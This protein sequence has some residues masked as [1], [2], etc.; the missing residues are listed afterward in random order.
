M[1][2]LTLTAVTLIMLA[3]APMWSGCTSLLSDGLARVTPYRVEIV[4]GNVVTREQVAAVKPGMTRDQ[5]RNALGAPL[6][7]DAFHGDRWDYVFTMRRQGLE[8]QRRSLVA[9]FSGDALKKIDAPT[10]LPSE[11]EFV[12]GIVK[13]AVAV[14]VPKL[15]LTDEE[16][17]ALPPPAKPETQAAAPS[18]T[19]RTYPPLEPR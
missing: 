19:R 10:D 14:T 9:W 13:T 5:V 15:V 8:P 3:S 18:V 7:T 1:P 11:N 16:R 17:R 4:Q 6:L 2:R 12:A